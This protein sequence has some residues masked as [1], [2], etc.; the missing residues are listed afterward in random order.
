MRQYLREFGRF[1]GN[2]QSIF[3]D[4]YSTFELQKYSYLAVFYRLLYIWLL[5]MRK[6][7]LYIKNWLKK[8][9]LLQLLKHLTQ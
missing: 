8:S 2:T 4:F 3:H 6:L 1:L 9:K 7:W 5:H